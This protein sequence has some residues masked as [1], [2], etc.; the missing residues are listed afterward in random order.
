MNL[1]GALKLFAIAL[2][3]SSLIVIFLRSWILANIHVADWLVAMSSPLI[4]IFG[5]I[6]YTFDSAAD[7]VEFRNIGKRFFRP[8][9]G[10]ID[11]FVS[12]LLITG[13]ATLLTTAV[14]W[15]R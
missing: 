11:F 10:W 5:F 7:P 3:L 15:G 8:V 13:F 9:R 2:A 1:T 12:L 6:L 14:V 4:I